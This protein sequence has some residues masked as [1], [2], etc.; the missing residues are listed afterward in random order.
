MADPTENTINDLLANYLRDHGVGVTTQ[1]SVRVSRG[2]RIPDFEARDGLLLYGEGEWN[3]SYLDGMY[4]AI[5]FAD[6]PGSSGYFLIGYPEALRDR[7]KQRRLT[8]SSP[9][10]L[11]GGGLGYR[12]ILKIAGEPPS[13]FRGP[14]GEI[15]KWLQDG[16]A[17]R[18]REDA[19]EFIALMRDVV[20]G[21]SLFLPTTGKY[22]SL[23]EH[24]IA[25]MPRDRGEL[26]TARR[27][28]AYLLLNQV[29]FYRI[30]QQ[31]GYSP[32]DPRKL[33]TPK[34]L[35]EIY[36]SVVLK[37]D[38]QAIFDNDVP[39]FFP[40]GSISFIRS[41]VRLVEDLQPEQLTRDL[42]GNIFHSL[43][44]LDL[45]KPIAAY[46]TNPI[47]ARLLAKLAID[48]PGDRVADF[49]CGSGTLMMAA[50]DRKAELLGDQF[51]ESVHRRFVE[52]EITGID[53]M[54]FAA[55]MA[56]V[57]LALRN[58]GYLTD[59]VRVAVADSS[60]L[61]PGAPIT[62]LQ[63]VMPRGQ[64]ALHHFK[65][66]EI[67][68]RKVREGAVS[69]AGA[70]KGFE[71][72]IVDVVMMNPPFTR[73]QLISK[74]FRKILTGRFE[75]YKSYASKEMNFFGYFIL[76]ADRFLIE[77]GRMAMVLP[78]SALRQQ[79]AEG[80]RRLLFEKYEIEFMITSTYRLAFSESTAF[81]EI[82]FVARKKRSGDRLTNLCVVASLSSGINESNMNEIGEQLRSLREASPDRG[83]I[84][85]AGRALGITLRLVDPAD[86]VDVR[87]WRR[88]LPGEGLEGFKPPASDRLAPL[89]AVVPKVIQGIRFDDS[90]DRVNVKNTILSL[91]RNVDVKMN[92][93]IASETDT[94][95]LAT[96]VDTAVT[97]NIP[98][99]VLEPTTRSPSGMERIEMEKP[100]DFIVVRRFPG[101]EQFWDERDPDAV[102]KRRVPHVRS[103]EAYLVAA[104]RNNVNLA[105]A[106]THLIA[107]VSPRPI[108]PTWS[109]WSIQVDSLEAARLLSLW[110]N[111]TFNIAQLIEAQSEV[112]GAWIGWLKR[113]LLDLPVLDLRALSLDEKDSLLRAYESIKG[114]RFPSLIEQLRSH[115]R[116]RVEIDSAIASVTNMAEFMDSRR[117]AALHES[118][119]RWIE[120][121]R[122]RMSR[123]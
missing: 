99:S 97:L 93:K 114:L 81:R 61:R 9:S 43:I 95:V 22:P 16:L 33:R 113:T 123:T 58:P 18:R 25:S 42:L 49:A 26:E 19:A 91:P 64:A 89:R 39:T 121:A 57:Q 74:D 106:G 110:W 21:L 14:L 8:T 80:L 70:G 87:D 3:D 62:S 83:S 37:D 5:Q 85:K 20:E 4:Q 15:P 1:P 90:S 107:Y 69:G 71:V 105:A 84:E 46:Y 88:L 6:I 72:D 24:I 34:D 30:L 56:V 53:I 36:F 82:L 108:A 112:G 120:A 67:E 101:D 44:P 103:R 77:G 75:D 51:D 60:R 23:F 86:F 73:K 48:S 66:E 94:E 35:K 122:D 104:G 45:R 41:M 96:N 78:A 47:A 119:L 65:E 109:F 55:H 52:D 92:W 50:Y 111:S 98:K 118:V 11:L 2:H 117:L 17:R 13:Y 59:R 10:D 115:F 12:G 40:E 102:L 31:R 79:S 63:R 116:G 76:L 29:V 38:Y 68:E 100:T 54:P 32:I 7:V 28:S 27:A